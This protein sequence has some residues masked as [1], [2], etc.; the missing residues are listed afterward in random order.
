MKM[1]IKIVD[2]ERWDERRVVPCI[3]HAPR[4]D[5]CDTSAA[6]KEQRKVG[7]GSLALRRR[8][9]RCT[10]GQ[11]KYR[12]VVTGKHRFEIE[13]S[14]SQNQKSRVVEREDQ[15]KWKWKEWT[16]KESPRQDYRYSAPQSPIVTMSL[17]PFDL[18]K[19]A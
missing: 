4:L 16:G 13:D 8:R 5:G 6:S 12:I 3:Y 2:M 10:T 7:E 17:S 14:E 15:P 11:D 1:K 9:V 19:T 18:A